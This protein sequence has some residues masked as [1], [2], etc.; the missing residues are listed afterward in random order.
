MT[1]LKSK[2]MREATAPPAGRVSS[3][4][5]S[6]GYS[7]PRGPP[8]QQ[9]TLSG[10]YTEQR[11]SDAGNA[12]RCRHHPACIVP[13]YAFRGSIKLLMEDSGQ[14]WRGADDLQQVTATF[15]RKNLGHS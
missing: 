8:A 1:K 4:W 15:E 9:A 7:Q 10:N 5:I 11:S 14:M 3:G 13:C 2:F 12:Y 6:K